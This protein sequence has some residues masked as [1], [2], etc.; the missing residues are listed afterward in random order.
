MIAIVASLFLLFYVFVPGSIFRF[1]TSLAVPLKKFQKTK[2]QEMTF[3]V[4]ASLLPFWLMAAFC[5]VLV[6]HAARWHYPVN[7]PCGSTQSEDSRRADYQTVIASLLSTKQ[8]DDAVGKGILWP[9]VSDVYRRQLRFLCWYYG[10]VVVEAWGFWYLISRYRRLKG[11]QAFVA[12]HVL[13]PSV[14]EW[15][16]I[17]SDF[18]IMTEDAKKR[19][20]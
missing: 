3:A 19:E 1:A 9:A 16:V 20:I 4:M 6:R 10:F 15:H 12:K 11:W 7:W 17:L 14:S 8:F 2:T 18:A 5:G 13:L